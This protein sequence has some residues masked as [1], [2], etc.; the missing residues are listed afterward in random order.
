M[1]IEGHEWRKD[2]P[3]INSRTVVDAARV[4]APAI[5]LWTSSRGTHQILQLVKCYFFSSAKTRVQNPEM[6]VSLI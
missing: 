3:S 5:R 1:I 6:S 2:K 4:A